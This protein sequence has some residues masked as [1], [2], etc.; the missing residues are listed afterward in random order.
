[1]IGKTEMS[2]FAQDDMIQK[3]NAEE[4]SALPESLRQN[5]IFLAGCR[6]TRRMVMRTDTGSRIHEN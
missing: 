3:G 1:L 6:I 2:V 4:I 5:A